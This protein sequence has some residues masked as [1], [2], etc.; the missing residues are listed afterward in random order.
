LLGFLRHNDDTPRREDV[1]DV[2][3]QP[4]G[5]VAFYLQIRG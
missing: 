4:A 1:T 3:T 2:R 5:Q